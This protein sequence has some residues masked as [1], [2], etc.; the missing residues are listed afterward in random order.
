[1][2]WIP[3]TAVTKTYEKIDPQQKSRNKLKTI[4]SYHIPKEVSQ[5]LEL[6][7]SW[8]LGRSLKELFPQLWEPLNQM[9][10]SNIFHILLFIEEF[11]T[12]RRLRKYDMTNVRLRRHYGLRYWI[13]VP[14][15]SDGKPHLIKGDRVMVIRENIQTNRKNRFIGFIE[16]IGNNEILV[17]FIGKKGSDIGVGLFTVCFLLNR[18]SILTQLIY[19]FV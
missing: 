19:K 5:V 11:E 3:S 7:G 10:Y 17:K 1:M 18:Y 16:K 12:Q 2:D 6:K 14:G 13:T 9:N 15:L 4:K 8:H